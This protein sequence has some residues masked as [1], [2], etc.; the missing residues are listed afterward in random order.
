[1]RK[2][3]NEIIEMREKGITFQEIGD[4]LGISRQYVHNTYIN[5]TKRLKKRNML[6]EEI[7][8]KNLRNY[9]YQNGYSVNDFYLLCGVVVTNRKSMIQKFLRGESNGNI[10]IIKKILEVTGMTF[11]EAFEEDIDVES[12]N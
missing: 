12:E 7:K 4:T 2:Y 8:Y 9:I 11:E 10:K 6:I 5:A 3:E 1:M